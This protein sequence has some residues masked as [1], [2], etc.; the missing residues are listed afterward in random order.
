LAEHPF[1]QIAEC[2]RCGSE[3]LRN[4]I[5]VRE[6]GRRDGAEVPELLRERDDAERARA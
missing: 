2:G 4:L 1:P 3:P 6:G 5:V